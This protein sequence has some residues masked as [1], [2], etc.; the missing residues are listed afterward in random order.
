MRFITILATLACTLALAACGGE[1][2]TSDATDVGEQGESGGATSAQGTRQITLEEGGFNPETLSVQVGQ[3][4]RVVNSSGKPT[5]IS[6]TGQ[7]DFNRRV[8]DNGR[9]EFSPDGP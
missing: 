4:I 3:L 6:G 2:G 8:D 5:T 7:A 9:H 1:R